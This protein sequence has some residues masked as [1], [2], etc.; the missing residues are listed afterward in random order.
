ML[1]QPRAPQV[2]GAGVRAPP[3]LLVEQEQQQLS[4]SE[5]VVNGFGGK[6]QYVTHTTNPLTGHGFGSNF[7]TLH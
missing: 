5:K 3:P 7:V 4:V 2:E 6:L 1:P